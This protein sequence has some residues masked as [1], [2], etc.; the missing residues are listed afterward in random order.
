[1]AESKHGRLVE[2]NNASGEEEEA[3]RIVVDRVSGELHLKEIIQ[4]LV[5][6]S[7][8]ADKITKVSVSPSAILAWSTSTF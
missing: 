5:Q 3:D 8:N 7:I 4:E 1:M 2:G 6:G